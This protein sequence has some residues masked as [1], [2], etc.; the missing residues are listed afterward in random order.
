MADEAVYARFETLADRIESQHRA[1]VRELVSHLAVV[2]AGNE[3]Q[4][5]F[6]A[7]AL[8]KI[9]DRLGNIETDVAALGGRVGK[10]EQSNASIKANLYD[11][12]STLSARVGVLETQVNRLAA[13]VAKSSRL[14]RS[15]SK[16]K[17]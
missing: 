15:T 11:T 16:R 12:I 3:K 8:G 5:K 4:H 7:Q 2:T 6:V 9:A 13:A 1:H 14:K 17:K 10:L